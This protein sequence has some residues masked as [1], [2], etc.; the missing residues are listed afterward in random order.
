M[1][2]LVTLIFLAAVLV[3]AGAALAGPVS[4]KNEQNVARH[5]A[6]VQKAV[7]VEASVKYSDIRDEL[8]AVGDALDQIDAS[9]TGPL[10]VAIAATTGTTK[11]ALQEVRKVLADMKV[12][13]K[14]LMQA[15]NKLVKKMKQAE[16]IDAQNGVK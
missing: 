13:Q 3:V 7:D 4:L 9:T 14:N 11:T 1:K 5:K 12:A 16:A 2:I 8:Q 15:S 10:G 6:T